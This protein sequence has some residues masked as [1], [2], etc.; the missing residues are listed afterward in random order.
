[1]RFAKGIN[2]QSRP[3]RPVDVWGRSGGL[4]DSSSPLRRYRRDGRAHNCGAGD[5]RYWAHKSVV[6]V[7]QQSRMRAYLT[8]ITAI[9]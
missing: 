2:L 7:I 8:A 6:V 3:A 1:M 9:P 4:S 5:R